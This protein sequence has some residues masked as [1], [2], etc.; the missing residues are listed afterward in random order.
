VRPRSLRYRVHAVVL[1]VVVLPPVWVWLS[2]TV[3]TG[4]LTLRHRTRAA[5]AEAIAGEQTPAA[6]A[7]VAER[8]RVHLRVYDAAGALV[9]DADRSP[10]AGMLSPMS[11]PFYGPRGRPDLDEIDR[12]MAPVLA[13]PEVTGANPEAST[14]RCDLLDD[15]LLLVCS[16]AQ[17]TPD[18]ALIHAMRGSPRLVRSLYEQRFQLTALALGVLLVGVVLA[19]WLGWRI[20][21]P[22]EHL[23]DQVVARTRSPR[24]S[25]EPVVSARPDEIGE[26]AAAFNQLLTALDERNRANTAF[27]AE[28]A[29]ELKNPVAAVRAA[30]EALGAGRPVEGERLERLHRVLGDASRR[31]EV[32][33]H[34]FLELAR[35]EAGL[36]GDERERVDVHELAAG[37]VSAMR[38]DER[39]AEVEIEVTGGA[40][41]VDAVPERLETALRNLLVN[42]VTH[43]RGTVRVEV[44]ERGGSV[45]IEVADDGPGVPDDVLPH[46][47]ERYH[48][49]RRGGT[50]LGLP[51]TRAIVEAHGGR[52]GVVSIRGRGA[53]FRV[54]L[55]RAPEVP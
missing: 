31:M 35:A 49:T 11:D 37:L 24:L 50:G 48:T 54:A 21:G 9:V 19:L 1:A 43:C 5:V 20:V 34:G 7:A 10:R 12:A 38:G 3:E 40:T 23:R 4:R 47:F 14:A 39:H 6:L 16:V 17:R 25:T 15:G 36:P 30:T 22:L 29:H 33:V 18:G 51:M 55:P 42:A 45:E 53:T 26:L 52:I 28:L 13:R 44:S 46:L 27:A 32:V 41:V 8:H 2:G